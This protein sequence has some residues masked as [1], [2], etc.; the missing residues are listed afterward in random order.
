MTIWKCL[1]ELLS[2]LPC[3][4]VDRVGA[5]GETL[6][7]LIRSVKE[8][9]SAE[10][11]RQ[12]AFTVSLI[13]LSAKMAKADGVVTE[14]EIEVIKKLFVVPPEE[15]ANVA[16]LFNLAKQDV[17][18]YDSYAARIRQL[19]LDEPSLLEDVLDGL[20]TIAAAD[21]VL[22]LNELAFLEHVAEI[23]A[24]PEARF[25]SIEARHAANGAG[26]PWHVLGLPRGTS[27]DDVKRHYRQLVSENHPDRLISRGLPAEAIR[28]ANDRLARIN[29]AYKMLQQEFA[30]QT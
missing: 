5:V 24:I 22:H 26:D 1:G 12:V 6:D 7:Q 23:F 16:R 13:A 9:F 27:A 14:D 28:L 2:C 10:S 21:G 15:L 30:P 17:A 18:G 29:V 11:R 20:F 19:H 8:Q 4:L 25:R 3:A